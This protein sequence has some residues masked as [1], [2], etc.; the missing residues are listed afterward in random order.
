MIVHQF[1]NLKNTNKVNKQI[2]EL[3]DNID[4]MKEEQEQKNQQ[5][6]RLSNVKDG[7]KMGEQLERLY[8]NLKQQV[9]VEM[10]KT[11]GFS[12]LI[13]GDVSDWGY[14]PL[15][16]LE[17][18]DMGFNSDRWTKK[19]PSVIKQFERYLWDG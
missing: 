8:K 15:M 2:Q 18:N 7:E 9:D 16:K 12:R 19:V 3:I 6:L 5:I 4:R 14:Q 13:D 10:K 17:G 1:N 11:V